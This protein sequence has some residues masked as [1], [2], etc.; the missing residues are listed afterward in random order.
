MR[1]KLPATRRSVTHTA[2]IG[3]TKFYLTVSFFPDG[4]PAEIFAKTQDGNRHG[5]QGWTDSLCKLISLALQSDDYGPGKVYQHMVGQD[6][7]PSG[8]TGE[9]EIGIAKSFPDYLARWTKLLSER[10]TERKDRKLTGDKEK[11]DGN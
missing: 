8:P 11:T 10:A 7:P 4:Q 6:F 1:H 2:N 5:L 9:P 3:G